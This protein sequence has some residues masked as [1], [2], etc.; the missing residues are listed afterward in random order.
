MFCK[1]KPLNQTRKTDLCLTRGSVYTH[2]AEERGEKDNNERERCAPSGCRAKILPG[3]RTNIVAHLRRETVKPVFYAV[4][5]TRS[6]HWTSSGF[7]FQNTFFLRFPSLKLHN[8]CYVHTTRINR[9]SSS[10][11]FQNQL[12]FVVCRLISIRVGK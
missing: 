7:R 11:R 6:T 2:T 8:T 9:F 4:V 10:I 1:K 3:R 5:R 12:F